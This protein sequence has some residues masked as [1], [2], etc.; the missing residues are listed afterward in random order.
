MDPSQNQKPK[1]MTMAQ[2][3]QYQQIMLQK[4]KQ[5]LAQKQE[6]QARQHA[7]LQA[8]A[9]SGQP[10]AQIQP[11]ASQTQQQPQ[12]Q[13]QKVTSVQS[14][15]NQQNQQT[16][17]PI[18][19][20]KAQLSQNQQK[21]SQ[22][23]PNQV[24]QNLNQPI[25]PQIQQKV[26]Q[27]QQPKLQN[28]PVQPQIG[29]KTV[30]NEPVQKQTPQIPKPFPVKTEPLVTRKQSQMYFTKLALTMFNQPIQC[31]QHQITFNFPF[32][33]NQEQELS[34]IQIPENAA[35][36]VKVSVFKKYSISFGSIL[37]ATY[38]VDLTKEF[39]L[40]DKV[41]IF[42]HQNPLK[43]KQNQAHA[44]SNTTFDF[45]NQNQCARFFATGLSFLLRLYR[46]T[47]K[48]LFV[49]TFEANNLV[50]K[51]NFYQMCALQF[52]DD[53][54]QIKLQIDDA[55]N[56]KMEELCDFMANICKVVD[57]AELESETA[58]NTDIQLL[59]ENEN[60][61]NPVLSK[62]TVLFEFENLKGFLKDLLQLQ[63]QIAEEEHFDE[64]EELRR[65]IESEQNPHKIKSK[66]TANKPLNTVEYQEPDI[67]TSQE[68]IQ[69]ALTYVECIKFKDNDKEQLQ[70]I[71]DMLAQV[72]D[73]PIDDT[74]DITNGKK[75]NA[76]ETA[77]NKNK[78]L[79]QYLQDFVGDLLQPA[80][81]DD[82][83][84]NMLLNDE[85]DDEIMLGEINNQDIED[86]LKQMEDDL[87]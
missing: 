41:T 29:Q 32:N 30:Q 20:Q 28:A 13:Q 65:E 11:Q 18:Q 54:E 62:S 8:Q 25:Q 87:I 27:I 37:S 5:L 17:Q 73:M 16:Q 6:M 39:H 47:H 9:K 34:S 84:M 24:N 33:F 22:P 50:L 83:N 68:M 57:K 58:E 51:Q 72:L 78:Q 63:N 82:I 43:F 76:K 7:K 56:S 64:L 59:I 61:F 69:N 21:I 44:E 19:P 86:E 26:T 45:Q 1:Q 75:Q 53:Y 23:V 67:K 77:N 14:Q 80:D 60:L 4:Q 71:L 81:Q 66:Q 15:V 38:G 36:N 42:M 3:L 70:M 2:Q 46:A 55:D 74:M 35:L 79:I 85:N 48:S 10:T 12:I 31:A 49:N 52:K 40:L